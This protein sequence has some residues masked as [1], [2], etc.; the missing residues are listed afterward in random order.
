MD[1]IILINL[2]NQ[3]LDHQGNALAVTEQEKNQAQAINNRRFSEDTVRN[4]QAHISRRRRRKIVQFRW[5]SSGGCYH[6]KALISNNVRGGIE[7]YGGANFRDEGA[8][9]NGFRLVQQSQAR[10]SKESEK[11][12]RSLMVKKS[13][14]KRR[15]GAAQ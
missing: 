9:W 6:A 14:E 2:I 8:E 12:E 10:L 4:S 3:L 5:W 1:R 11:S 15:K 13:K 7:V